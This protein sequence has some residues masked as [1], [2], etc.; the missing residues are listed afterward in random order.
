MP[1]KAW[2]AIAG[3]V[4]I[5]PAVH[6]FRNTRTLRIMGLLN[7]LSVTGQKTMKRK[8]PLA[9]LPLA[10]GTLTVHAATLV[11]YQ[12]SALTGARNDWTN[13]GSAYAAPSAWTGDPRTG[14]YLLSGSTE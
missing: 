8:L 14:N 9:L 7:L 6:F 3:T 5:S 4:K 11:D 12:F 10:A 2:P 1:G 13:I